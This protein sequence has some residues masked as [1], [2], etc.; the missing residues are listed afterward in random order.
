MGRELR[1]IH[2]GWQHPRNERGQYIPLHDRAYSEALAEYEAGRAL[3][4]QGQHPAQ[5]EWPA[6]T[7]HHTYEEWVGEA[8]DP[9]YYRTES[10]THQQ[11]AQ[12]VLYEN[13]TEGTPASPALSAVRFGSMDGRQRVYAR[14][15][16]AHSQRMEAADNRCIHAAQRASVRGR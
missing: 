6:E 1:R 15:N 3:W 16:K 12:W 8:P 2:R 5:L 14:R 4:A 13:V 9:R 10:W 11:T 7:A